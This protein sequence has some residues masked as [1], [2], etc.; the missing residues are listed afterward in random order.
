M[1]TE[2]LSWYYFAFFSLFQQNE[3]HKEWELKDY[4]MWVTV[5]WEKID[6]HYD[7]MLCNISKILI[8]IK[9]QIQSTSH[10]KPVVLLLEQK[11]QLH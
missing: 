4:K 11:A 9:D 6:I 7:N 2:W 1:S 3:E 10:Q 8:S 5:D